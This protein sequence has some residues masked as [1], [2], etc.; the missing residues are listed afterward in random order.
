MEGAVDLIFLKLG[1]SVITDKE[2]VE[3]L[4]PNVLNRLA[5]EIALA[6][7]EREELALLIGHG[8]GSFGHV[9]AA[10]YGTRE[11]V[12]GRDGWLGFAKVSAAAA[13]LHAAVM[14][15]LRNAGIPALG[16]QPSASAL[17]QDGVLTT[18]AVEPITRALRAG[19]VP[20][21]YGDV[22]FDSVRGGTIISTEEILSFLA[23][24]LRPSWLLLAGK[25]DGVYDAH[26]SPISH[27]N[28]E[29]LEDVAVALGG[30][31]GTDVT[32][33]MESK[34]RA[35][36][37]L[38]QSLR[39][40]SIRVFSVRAAGLLHETLLHPGDARGTVIRASGS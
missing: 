20:V 37:T 21:I 16:L 2:G 26:G 19:L 40:L 6:L 7:T 17:C 35:M 23:P 25:T 12:A 34:V 31:Y 11:G 4:Q 27:I 14:G 22:A 39:G 13:R 5:T 24:V 15:A 3:A 32:G 18:L 28:E 1:G 36:V 30:S 29:N 8:S 38:A 33:G 10:Q 9:A